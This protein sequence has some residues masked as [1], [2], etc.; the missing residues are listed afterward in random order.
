MMILQLKIKYF[1]AMVCL[2]VSDIV[3]TGSD[4]ERKLLIGAHEREHWPAAPGQYY[5]LSR[6]SISQ[7]CLN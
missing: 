5:M 2:W 4:L 7:I 6:D 3:G 1:I